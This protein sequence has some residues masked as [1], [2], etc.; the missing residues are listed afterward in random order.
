MPFDRPTLADLIRTHEA[1]AE[2]RL[3]GAGADL[4]RTA[5]GVLARVHSGALHG[6]Y[7]YAAWIARQI[8][9]DTAESELLDRHAAIWGLA[10]KAAGPATGAVTLSGADG[11]IIPAG[12]MLRR[13]DGADYAT[14]AEATVAGDTADAA[15]TALSPGAAGNADAGVALA[16]ISPVSGVLSRA[17]VAAGG[18][19]GGADIETD[20]ALRARVLARIQQPPHGGAG[21]DYVTWALEV[22]GVT[23]AWVYPGEMGLGTVT[24]RIMTDDATPDGIPGAATVQ[25]VADH[26]AERRPVTAEVFVAAPLAVPLDLEISSLVPATSAVRAAIAAEIADLIR[27]EAE[28]G[29]TILISHVREAISIAAGEHDHVLVSPDANVTR[30]TGEIAVTGTITWN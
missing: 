2:S 26:V 3:G 16:L 25:A 14:D 8:L 30:A 20:D 24:V 18:L 10:R 7:G 6:L 27:R 23:R 22:A 19:T 13:A 1:D 5:L 12:T 4:R 11:S 21:F 29:G 28:P 17:T 15:V 9:P